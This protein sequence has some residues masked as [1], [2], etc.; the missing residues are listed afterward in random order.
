MQDFGIIFWNSL[1]TV[2]PAYENLISLWIFQVSNL[3]SQYF[4]IKFLM[5]NSTT[6]E[7]DLISLGQIYG[8]NFCHGG[9]SFSVFQTQLMSYCF[10][11]Q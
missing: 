10:N 11:G 9:V 7:M 8:Q 3:I 1:V 6:M 4:G 5:K 2:F